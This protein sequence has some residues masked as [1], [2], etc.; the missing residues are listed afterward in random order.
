MSVRAKLQADIN[1]TNE[2]SS[3]AKSLKNCIQCNYCKYLNLPW[4][5]SL[6]IHCAAALGERRT[7]SQSGLLYLYML[8]AE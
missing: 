7:G 4:H 6:P 2:C 5:Q 1:D 8:D 3:F